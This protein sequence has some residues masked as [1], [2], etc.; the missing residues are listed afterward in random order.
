MEF[1]QE[2]RFRLHQRLVYLRDG[3]GWTRQW[4]FP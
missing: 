1:W 4:L 2:G 3:A